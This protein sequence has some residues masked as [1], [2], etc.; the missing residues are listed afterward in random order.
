MKKYAL[1]CLVAALASMFAFQVFAW[2]KPIPHRMRPVSGQAI[3]ERLAITAPELSTVA[4][5]LSANDGDSTGVATTV[6]TGFETWTVP[7]NILVQPGGSTTDVAAG[8]VVVTGKD[9]HGNAISD[10]IAV[11]ANQATMSTGTYAFASVSSI[12]FPAEDAPYAATWQI[13]LGNKLGLSRCMDGDS[14]LGVVFGGTWETTRPTVVADADEIEKNT[15]DLNSDLDGS[16][17][18]EIFS[19]SN[20]RCNP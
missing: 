14:V 11:T 20:F 13:G 3:I 16:S 4:G 5:V 8:N 15:I 1:H 7:R 10:T 2:D 6:S 18:V 9:Y 12:V 17:D 19:I